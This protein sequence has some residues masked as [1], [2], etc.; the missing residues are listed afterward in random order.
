MALAPEK[1]SA[2]VIKGEGEEEKRGNSWKCKERLDLV[3]KEQLLCFQHFKLFP[4]RLMQRGS[5]SISRLRAVNLPAQL[6]R[7]RG[8]EPPWEWT[9][10]ASVRAG[11]RPHPPDCFLLPR[12]GGVIPATFRGN[13][14]C[15]SRRK[16]WV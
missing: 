10:G 15:V 8:R 11:R 3:D 9:Q 6:R 4:R 14:K 1:F 7:R 2:D 12:Q 16:S 13:C 5:L